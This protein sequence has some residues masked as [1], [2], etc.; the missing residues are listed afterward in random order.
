MFT[1]GV[2]LMKKIVITVLIAGAFALPLVLHFKQPKVEVKSYLSN[3]YYKPA[4]N[5]NE[6][7][8]KDIFM[9]LLHP[10]IDKAIRNYYKHPYNHDPWDVDILNIERPNGY[11]TFLFILKLKVIPY[12]GPHI[13]VGVD[14]ITISVSGTGKVE[15]QKFEHIKSYDI[16]AKPKEEKPNMQ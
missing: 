7:I 11:R 13:G 1:Y 9:S 8:Y 16:P 15:I 4:E 14:Y 12:Y 2:L 5:S 3:A 6:E 10:Y